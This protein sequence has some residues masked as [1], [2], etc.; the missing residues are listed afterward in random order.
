M[1]RNIQVKTIRH[2]AAQ[3][4]PSSAAAPVERR[5]MPELWDLEVYWKKHRVEVAVCQ[6]ALD[7]EPRDWP[8]CQKSW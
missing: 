6:V 2:Q 7:F 5:G 3:D 4:L 8:L 1:S